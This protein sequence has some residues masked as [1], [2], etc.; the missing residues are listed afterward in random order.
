MIILDTH[1][2]VDFFSDNSEDAEKL[3]HESESGG[4]EL[5]VSAIT[6]S[7]VFYII[8]GK[9]GHETAKISID[10]MKAQLNIIPVN[11]EIAEKAGE[12]KFR[13][14]GKGKKGMPMADAII[15]AT[16]WVHESQLITS[17]PHFDK[18]KEI[19]VRRS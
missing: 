3:I 6:L 14:A 18:V 1:V 17:D 2:L 15:A 16:A 5:A 9:A 4:L 19:K 10:T 8:A 13:Y 11:A 12:L 7:E